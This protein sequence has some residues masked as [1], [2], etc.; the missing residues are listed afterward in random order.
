MTG[1]EFRNLSAHQ[2]A[3]VA[4]AVLLDGREA[5]SYLE[6]DDRHGKE[7]AE[8]AAE[9]ASHPPYLLMPYIASLLRSALRRMGEA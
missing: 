3:V 4:V 9:L 6:G 1:V 8:A 5:E 2:R 7:L